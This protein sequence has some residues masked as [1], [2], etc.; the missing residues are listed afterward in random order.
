MI[1]IRAKITLFATLLSLA[2][3][4]ELPRYFASDE[5]V[6]RAGGRELRVC[7]LESVI[8]SG[9]SP[10]DSVAFMRKYIDRWVVK[11]L[12][13][14]EA[15][16]LFSSSAEDI[17][18]MVEEY[19]QSLLIRKLDRHYVEQSMDTV[20]SDNEIAA[21][22]A[23]H[24]GDFRLDRTL[25]KGRVVRLDL[26]NRQAGKLKSAMGGTSESH[27]RDFRDL[28]AKNE[29]EVNDFRTQW[30]DFSEFLNCLPTRR[31][32]SYASVLGTTEVQEM[33]DDAARYYFQIVEVRRAGDPIPLER[34]RPTIRRILSNRRQSEIIRRH[35]EA[36]CAQGLRDGDVRIYGTEDDPEVAAPQEKREQAN[37]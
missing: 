20:F 9:L 12:K 3:C 5:T 22:Y 13:L 36:L 31:S 23:A 17:D 21:Y 4:R 18:R 25:V 1:K 15:E 35:E 33:R 8:P 16:V 34:L 2:G 32:Q 10:S 37:I 7:D 24:G 28:C 26:N 29:F 11:Q 27:Q 14:S 30:V 6:A 19:R